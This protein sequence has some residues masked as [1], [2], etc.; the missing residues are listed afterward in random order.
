MS[1]YAKIINGVVDNIIIA[2]KTFVDSQD[3]LYVKCED[4]NGVL[5]KNIFPRIDY[6]YDDNLDM[7]I[8]PQP[9][10][11]WILNDNYVWESP[12]PQPEL[13][14]YQVFYWDEEN[15]RWVV[16]NTGYIP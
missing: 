12:L 9:Y 7:F 15:I 13:E 16:I 5:T 3:D 8:A 10:P 14:E 2:D 1:S 4:N 6:K 11:S